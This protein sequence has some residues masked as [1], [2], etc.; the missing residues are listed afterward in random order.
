M[1]RCREQEQSLTIAQLKAKSKIFLTRIEF[2]LYKSKD[3]N[4]SSKATI[5]MNIVTRTKCSKAVFHSSLRKIQIQRI[6]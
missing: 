4:N 1:K 5:N 2:D 6:S 3:S